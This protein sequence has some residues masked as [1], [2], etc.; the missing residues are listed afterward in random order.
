MGP[1]LRR[2]DGLHP[3]PLAL[4]SGGVETSEVRSWVDRRSEAETGEMGILSCIRALVV[5]EQICCRDDYT[6]VA[7]ASSLGA[8]A[9]HDGPIDIS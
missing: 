9:D 6:S 5:V 1:G 4:A 7:A 2:G 3:P 8:H